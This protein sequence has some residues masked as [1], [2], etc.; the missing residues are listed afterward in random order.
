MIVVK[1]TS[2]LFKLFMYRR[3][4]PWAIKSSWKSLCLAGKRWNTRWYETLLITVSP[5]AT[6]RTSIHW[7]STQVGTNLWPFSNHERLFLIIFVKIFLFVLLHFIKICMSLSL[8]LHIFEHTS[9]VFWGVFYFIFFIKASAE[10]SLCSDTQIIMCRSIK[11][12]T[13]RY[14]LV[15]HWEPAQ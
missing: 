14:L 1:H 13:Q 15:L 4:W 5:S 2:K 3:L 6:W 9:P 7:A 8:I 10:G 11:N 12:C